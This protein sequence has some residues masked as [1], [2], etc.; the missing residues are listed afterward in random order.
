MLFFYSLDFFL[1]LY[2]STKLPGLVITNNFKIMVVL[3][4]SKSFFFFSNGFLNCCKQPVYMTI[5][6]RPGRCRAYQ[7][8]AIQNIFEQA[9]IF[10]QSH[11]RTPSRTPS[12][13]R[14]QY[15]N[16]TGQPGCYLERCRLDLFI[17]M[18]DQQSWPILQQNLPFTFEPSEQFLNLSGL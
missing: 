17:W 8:I 2:F 14:L 12:R 4:L 3:T 15:S 18:P 13:Y 1:N 16:Q 9:D 10:T 7:L 6:V 5:F 11:S